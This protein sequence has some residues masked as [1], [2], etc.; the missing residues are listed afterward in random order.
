MANLDDVVTVQKNGVVAVN[1]L[2]QVMEAFNN[3]YSNFV[4]EASFA[5][6]TT[7]TLVRAGAGRVITVCVVAAAAG[8]K[9][10]DIDTVGSASNSNAIFAI[11]NATGAYT[12]TFPVSTGIVVKPA[13]GSIV[14]VSYSV[15]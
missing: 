12:I 11:P 2:V 4:G 14:S 9:I 7:D 5:G 10:H 8:G 6:I 13:A 1:T 15:E 3:L